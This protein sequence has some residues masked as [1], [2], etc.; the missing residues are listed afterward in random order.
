[1]G[2]LIDTCIWIDVERG[3]LAP[4]DIAAITGKEPVYLSPVT[5][6]ELRF[7]AEM[8]ASPD[9]K[10]KRLAAIHRLK[11]KPILKIDEVTGDIF[12][13]IAASLR[14][15]GKHHKYRVQDLWLASQA[16]QY[17][18]SFLTFNKKDFEDIPGLS[19]VAP[20]RG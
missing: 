7:G 15:I 6:A 8:A 4:A 11:R 13:S 12:G 9:I 17:G 20:I 16:I 14:A 3:S 18:L 2:F 5:I 1:M 19:L 10:Q